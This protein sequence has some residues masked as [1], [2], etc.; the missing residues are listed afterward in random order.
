MDIKFCKGA[1]I[2][3]LHMARLFLMYLEAPLE[4]PPA[5]LTPEPTSNMEVDEES[6][7]NI[8]RSTLP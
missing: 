3:P 1:G 5:E 2:S 8:G 7:N 4:Q 6:I